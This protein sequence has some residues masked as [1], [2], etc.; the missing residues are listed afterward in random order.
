MKK[1]IILLPF[2][3]LSKNYGNTV[4]NKVKEFVI[5]DL[6][7][8]SSYLLAQLIHTESRGE[9]YKGMRQV[10]SVVLNRLHS[11]FYPNTL[12]SVIFQPYQ[13]ACDT[14]SKPNQ[15]IIDLADSLLLHHKPDNLFYFLNPVKTKNKRMLKMSRKG[16]RIGNHIFF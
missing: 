16:I 7:V 1:I 9:P 3:L 14:L 8:N 6:K 5:S 11:S 15:K 12:D 4:E 2:L 13:F 10:G